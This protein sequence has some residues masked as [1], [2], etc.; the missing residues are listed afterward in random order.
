MARRAQSLIEAIWRGDVPA[1]R[2]HLSA[3][4]DP[5]MRESAVPALTWALEL[6]D[7]GA[8]NQIVDALIKAGASATPA[9][10]RAAAQ[11]D[12]NLVMML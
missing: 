1:V 4:A 6:R 9:L 8:R 10:P 3:G 11:G 5:N 7:K 2:S 12:R